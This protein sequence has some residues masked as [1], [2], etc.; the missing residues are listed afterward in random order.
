[1]EIL[2]RIH[3][4]CCLPLDLYTRLKQSLRYKYDRDTENL[5]K[6]INELP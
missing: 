5:N 2:D 4:D 3:T 6:F 1:M